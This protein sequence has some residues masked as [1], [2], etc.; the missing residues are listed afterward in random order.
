MFAP[1]PIATTPGLFSPAQSST[2]RNTS[3]LS[4]R[5]ITPALAHPLGEFLQVDAGVVTHVN[6]D[7][8]LPIP[9]LHVQIGEVAVVGR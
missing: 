3:P 1:A 7:N 2:K 5:G 9:R 8:L 4:M 6:T